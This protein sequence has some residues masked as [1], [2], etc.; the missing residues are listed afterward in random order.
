MKTSGRAEFAVAWASCPCV[1][2][3]SWPCQSVPSM[4]GTPVLLFWEGS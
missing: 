2:G 4:G 1:A 3:P